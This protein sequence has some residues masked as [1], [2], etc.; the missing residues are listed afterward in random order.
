MLEFISSIF[1]RRIFHPCIHLSAALHRM[2]EDHLK[3]LTYCELQSLTID[4]MKKEITAEIAKR[5]TDLLLSLVEKQML[6][7]S[8]PFSSDLKLVDSL[9][10]LI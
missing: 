10:L 6:S 7:F 3:H 9:I 5:V 8:P 1:V 2:L 4:D